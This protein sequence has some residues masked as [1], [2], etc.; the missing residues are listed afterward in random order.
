MER[1][2][3]SVAVKITKDGKEKPF[4]LPFVCDNEIWIQLIANPGLGHTIE[5]PISNATIK[6]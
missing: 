6:S 1:I 2:D 4:N 3:Y 5:V